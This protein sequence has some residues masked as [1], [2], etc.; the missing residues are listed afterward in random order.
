MRFP[1]SHVTLNHSKIN[2]HL[3]QKAH[4]EMQLENFEREQKP[5]HC[6]EENHNKWTQAQD[7]S[8]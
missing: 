4:Y 8:P 5:P 2:G 6:F 3:K 1:T 7:N